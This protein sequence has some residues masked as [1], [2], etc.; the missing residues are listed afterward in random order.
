[1]NFLLFLVCDEN[2]TAQG[3]LNAECTATKK[4]NTRLPF[5]D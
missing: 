1:M 5:N 4:G 3:Y 2:N